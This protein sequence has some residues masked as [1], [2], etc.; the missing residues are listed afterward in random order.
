MLERAT[1][2]GRSVCLSAHLSVCPTPSVTLVIYA[3]TVQDIEI[4][5]TPCDRAMFLVS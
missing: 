2:N 1:A 3:Y 5:F 4:H